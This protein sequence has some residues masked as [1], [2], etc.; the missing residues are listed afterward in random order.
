[1]KEINWALWGLV[2]IM[3]IMLFAR[4]TPDYCVWEEYC[5]EDRY[6]NLYD[7][8]DEYVCYY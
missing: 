2:G 1:M 5:Y 4:C 3:L 6:G 7:C 8:Y